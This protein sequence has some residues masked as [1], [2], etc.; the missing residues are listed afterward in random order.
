[1]EQHPRTR[2]IIQYFLHAVTIIGDISVNF[3]KSKYNSEIA[4]INK[5]YDKAERGVFGN[6]DLNE[7][8]K[9]QEIEKLRIKFYNDKVKH[10]Q[11]FWN[12]ASP[13]HGILDTEKNNDLRVYLQ[14]HCEVNTLDLI[15]YCI[16]LMVGCDKQLNY[17]MA[18]NFDAI[19]PLAIKIDNFFNGDHMERLQ[20][21]NV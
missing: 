9:N 2:D 3:V 18:R 13:K 17:S 6:N 5:Q 12:A 11:V 4:K 14:Q 8:E 10:N 1:M 15:D 16:A 7:T 21:K 19:K 20:F